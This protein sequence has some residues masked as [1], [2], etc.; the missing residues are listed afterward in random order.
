MGGLP[1]ELSPLCVGPVSRLQ[2]LGRHKRPLAPVNAP[3]VTH[4]RT[5][6][7]SF[8]QVYEESLGFRYE[9]L[10]AEAMFGPVDSFDAG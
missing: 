6:T 5:P 2:M 9:K 7:F 4:K 8:N 1:Q 10:T 3:Q